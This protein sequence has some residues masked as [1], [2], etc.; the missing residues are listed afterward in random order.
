MEKK[1][2]KRSQQ[3]QI[4]YIDSLTDFE[5]I[6]V[7]SR[8]NGLSDRTMLEGRLV[9]DASDIFS[10]PNSDISLHFPGGKIKGTTGRS[11]LNLAGEPSRL[12][13]AGDHGSTS[14]LTTSMYRFP[15]NS[16]QD[17]C[18]RWLKGEEQLASCREIKYDHRT[19]VMYSSYGYPTSID[20]LSS[21]ATGYMHMVVA[22]TEYYGKQMTFLEAGFLPILVLPTSG[23]ALTRALIEIDVADKIKKDLK[24]Y[25][26]ISEREL[27]GIISTSSRLYQI[28]KNHTRDDLQGWSDI[29]CSK[30]SLWEMLNEKHRL[31]ASS[32]S[33]ELKDITIKNIYEEYLDIEE[34]HARVVEGLNSRIDEYLA[35]GETK[36]QLTAIRSEYARAVRLLTVLPSAELIARLDEMGVNAPIYGTNDVVFPTLNTST[37]EEESDGSDYS[38]EDN[39]GF[40]LDD[41]DSP[42]L[43]DQQDDGLD[44]LD[45]TDKEVEEE[46]YKNES[47]NRDDDGVI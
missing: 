3:T 45:E 11:F 35:N 39:Y 22:L 31:N 12:I 44:E 46:D 5:R 1:A 30:L 2:K 29:W 4:F 40:T 24:Q 36:E 19:S 25:T 7:Q 26:D 23:D 41:E 21:W 37:V 14:L 27:P 47:Y 43:A 34:L 42:K 33:W 16:R 6:L 15:T 20:E 38:E 10:D 17:L 13:A 8:A 18:F 28:H 9:R 32:R